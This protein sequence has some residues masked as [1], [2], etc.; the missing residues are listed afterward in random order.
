MISAIA[1]SHSLNVAHKDI[2][3]DNFLYQTT[4]DDSPLKLIDTGYSKIFGELKGVGKRLGP[5]SDKG[6]NNYN[7]PCKRYENK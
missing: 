6:K 4:L 5:D 2:R 7:T 1:H 3:P